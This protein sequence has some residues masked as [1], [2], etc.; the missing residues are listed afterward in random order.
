MS[1]NTGDTAFMFLCT[2]LVL[3]MTPGLAFFY[4]GL[5]RKRHVL[6]I[7]MQSFVAIGIVSVFW[8]LLGYSLTFGTD[9]GHIIGGLNWFGLKGVGLEPN[10][11]YASNIPHL[12]FFAF[13]L[14]F[15][16]ITPAVVSGSTAER[17]RFPAFVLFISFWSLLVYVPLAH[18]VWGNGGWLRNLGVLDFA[19]GT[20]VE[21]CSGVS[22]LIAALVVGKRFKHKSEA[23]I[24]HHLPNVLLGGG[25]LWFGWF[26]FNAGGALGANGTAVLA[27]VTTQLAAAAGMLGWMII[28]VFHRGKPTVLGAIS[29][30]IAAL[31]AIT[32]AAG[33]VSPTSSLLIGFVAGGLSYW[34]VSILKEKFGYDDTLDAFGIH[35]IGGTWGML[36]TGLFASL[37]SNQ[38]GAN[39][40]FFGGGIHQVLIQVLAI[41]TTYAFTAGMTWGILKVVKLFTPLQAT[42]EEQEYGLD[43]SQHGENAYP[44]FDLAGNYQ[45]SWNI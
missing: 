10:P 30:V 44:D 28:E 23:S 8:T 4:G 40:L 34:A 5:V 16:I 24:P 26:G 25:L 12:L 38:N 41:L 18:W 37:S 32:P 43:L 21:I 36:A 7:M 2:S 45:S 11:D 13:Q 15:A 42:E 31:V 17:L 9:H 33:F 29:G 35:G 20:V 1:I 27:L 39:G 19:G 22:G 6:S 3:L 14:M